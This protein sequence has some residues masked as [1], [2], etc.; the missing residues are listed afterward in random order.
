MNRST[1]RLLILVILIIIPAVIYVSNQG[2][3]AIT[4]PCLIVY[5]MLFPFAFYVMDWLFDEMFVED[6]DYRPRRIRT[7][8]AKYPIETPS[9]KYVSPPSPPP[10]YEIVTAPVAPPF[11]A[12]PPPRQYQIV[13]APVVYTVQQP[14]PKIEIIHQ[15]IHQEDQRQI[16]TIK[17]SVVSRSSIK[18]ERNSESKEKE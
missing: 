5:F 4:T 1:S 7:S 15:E 10:Q 18:V 14:T 12:P 2:T 11:Y 8:E 16:L 13:P 3:P 9:Y 17:D 6:E